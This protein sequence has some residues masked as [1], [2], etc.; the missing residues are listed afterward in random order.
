MKTPSKSSVSTMW[1]G[2]HCVQKPYRDP[3]AARTLS[4]K[5]WCQSPKRKASNMQSAELVRLM[6]WSNQ[7]AS[8]LIPTTSTCKLDPRDRCNSKMTSQ[9]ESGLCEVCRDIDFVAILQYPQPGHE[10]TK[11]ASAKLTQAP[12]SL[13]VRVQTLLCLLCGRTRLARQRLRL[14]NS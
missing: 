3:A 2:H 6:S 5:Y 14:S 9:L 13:R 4:H 8:G 12:S 1:P 7:D 10:D 11:Q